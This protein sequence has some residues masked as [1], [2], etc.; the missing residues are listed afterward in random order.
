MAVATEAALYLAEDRSR[1]KGILVLISLSPFSP[2][3][4]SKLPAHEMV[5]PTFCWVFPFVSPL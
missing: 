4:V 2:F 5:T 3:I 1:E